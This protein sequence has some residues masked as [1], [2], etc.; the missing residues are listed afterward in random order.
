MLRF[1]F[2]FDMLTVLSSF[3]NIMYV[4]KG[5]VRLHTTHNLHTTP[6]SYGNSIRVEVTLNNHYT[7]LET[8]TYCVYSIIFGAIVTHS[9]EYSIHTDRCLNV[10]LGLIYFSNSNHVSDAFAFNF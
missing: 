7:L 4:L 6:D 9:L 2:S 10:H 1:T 8:C 5:K 3:N